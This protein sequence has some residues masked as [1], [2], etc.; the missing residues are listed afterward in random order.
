MNVL[1]SIHNFFT[2]KHIGEFNSN[3]YPLPT[4]S[5]LSAVNLKPLFQSYFL[6]S[7]VEKKLFSNILIK[8]KKD[9][10]L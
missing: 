7:S 10:Y 8:L 4:P 9:T 3:V 5:Q 6:I 2:E 1:Y